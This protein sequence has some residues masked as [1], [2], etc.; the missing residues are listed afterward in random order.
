MNINNIIILQ[1]GTVITIIGK[2]IPEYGIITSLNENI[3]V[4]LYDG[5]NHND[6][7]MFIYNKQY[8]ILD[9]GDS[10]FEFIYSKYSIYWDMNKNILSS[11]EI[12]NS[13]KIDVESVFLPVKLPDNIIS[14]DNIISLC[15]KGWII[16]DDIYYLVAL[17]EDLSCNKGTDFFMPLT[18][19]NNDNNILK[20]LYNNYEYV[21]TYIPRNDSDIRIKISDDEAN[22]LNLLY[23]YRYK[24][25]LKNDKIQLP[26]SKDLLLR[27]PYWYPML[28]TI[29]ELFKIKNQVNQIY[30][31]ENNI[32]IGINNINSNK[33][34][35]TI[36]SIKYDIEFSN[37]FLR[38]FITPSGYVYYG[39]PK[40][41]PLIYK[42][43]TS[44]L[45]FDRSID[46]YPFLRQIMYSPNQK[47]NKDIIEYDRSPSIRMY[48]F[49]KP[50]YERKSKQKV[51]LED[52]SYICNETIPD[53]IAN[54]LRIINRDKINIILVNFYLTELNKFQFYTTNNNVEKIREF[55][56]ILGVNKISI[57]SPYVISDD[58]KYI[59]CNITNNVSIDNILYMYI[60]SHEQIA[61]DGIAYYTT[62]EFITFT[63]M[64]ISYMVKAYSNYNT[65]SMLYGFNF[66]ILHN[67]YKL[68]PDHKNDI[69][70]NINTLYNT[71][72]L[73][74]SDEYYKLYPGRYDSR[75]P[76]LWNTNIDT[77]YTKYNANISASRED[78]FYDNNQWLYI[79]EL[80]ISMKYINDTD[81]D[82]YY[83]Y[84]IYDERMYNL[85]TRRLIYK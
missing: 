8:N 18:H 70:F 72:E 37:P 9:I 28:Y 32:R 64:N 21:L 11:Y 77:L 58:G 27:F 30:H 57:R 26:E 13:Q 22:I 39:I 23:V 79:N 78:D 2:Y 7:D 34:N 68:D 3:S 60:Y 19:K 38:W 1:A 29:K 59:I 71:N 10:E 85:Y 25:I 20:V 17:N 63:P 53:Y 76:V 55:L 84:K 35:D 46:L 54:A 82:E 51:Q 5:Y 62:P 36:M 80:G 42:F 74:S 24:F 40:K 31:D 75:A 48:Y 47:D 81:I 12:K 15:S 50:K 66:M 45:A 83:S 41:L 56:N 4:Y 67:H 61:Y 73:L 52:K 14:K 44:S 43:C 16:I 65:N 6:I 33:L 69:Y 49:D